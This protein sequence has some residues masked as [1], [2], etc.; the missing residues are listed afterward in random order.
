MDDKAD[1]ERWRCKE[2]SGRSYRLVVGRVEVV[3]FSKRVLIWPPDSE[4]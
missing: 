4:N 2:A 3:A 1:E